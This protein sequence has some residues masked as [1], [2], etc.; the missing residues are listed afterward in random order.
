MAF[1]QLKRRGFITAR[2]RGAVVAGDGPRAATGHAGG[3]LSTSDSA[4]SAAPP[5]R[6]LKCVESETRSNDEH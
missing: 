2:R 4:L 1:A 3:H 5:R 6:L